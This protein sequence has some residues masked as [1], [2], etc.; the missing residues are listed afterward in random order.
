MTKRDKPFLSAFKLYNALKTLQNALKPWETLCN[1]SS[2]FSKT[3][4]ANRDK[5]LQSVTRLYKALQGIFNRFKAFLK[6]QNA[7]KQLETLQ[8]ALKQW[9]TLWTIE[10]AEKRFVTLSHAMLKNAL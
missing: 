2:R 4:L 10:N 6:L 8:N 7:L 3:Y 1:A 5:A 9:E